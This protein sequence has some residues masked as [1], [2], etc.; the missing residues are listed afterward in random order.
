VSRNLRTL[1]LAKVGTAWLLAALAL[2]APSGAAAQTCDDEDAGD[3]DGGS[4]EDGGLP[5]LVCEPS[6]SGIPMQEPD[7]SVPDG[8]VEV[9]AGAVV[10][11]ACSCETVENTGGGAIHVC[12]GARDH[13]VCQQLECESSIV[14]DRACPTSDVVLCCEMPAR[15]LYAQLYEDCEHPNCETG[16]RAQCTDFGGSIT[17]GACVVEDTDG[18]SDES[19]G[20]CS[21]HARTRSFDFSAGALCLL[22]VALAARSRRRNR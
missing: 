14:R 1:A 20:G 22:G 12:T 19:G 6:D 7:A 3:E 15:G 21:V 9:D 5:G 8:S 10:G 11:A 13:D 16:F 4:D 17:E 18:A 2:Y